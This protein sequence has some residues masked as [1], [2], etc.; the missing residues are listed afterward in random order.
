MKYETILLTHRGA[1]AT[2]SLNRPEKL[3]A[4]YD[5]VYFDILHALDVLA[6]DGA[7]RALVLTGAGR[8]FCAGGDIH[9]DVGTLEDRSARGI[10]DLSDLSQKVAAAVYEFPKPVIA[11]VNARLAPAVMATSLASRSAP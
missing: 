1:V 5:Q 3:N 6:K 11:M 8:A 4:L 10:L 7:V 2:L 9:L